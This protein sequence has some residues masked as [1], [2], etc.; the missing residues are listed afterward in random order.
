MAQTYI[1]SASN[2]GAV[3]TRSMAVATAK[4]LMIRY[5]DIVGKIDLDNSEWAK[6]LFRRMG[7]T[8]RKRT[9]AK[10]EMP[11][12]LRKEAELLFHHQIVERVETNQNPHSLVLNFD[13][14]RVLKIC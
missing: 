12:G 1:R 7:Y 2:R 8:G 6:R 11:A 14:T 4:A 10:L 13:R 9:T 3:V 5:S